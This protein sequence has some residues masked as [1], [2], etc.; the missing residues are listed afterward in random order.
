[1]HDNNQSPVLKKQRIDKVDIYLGLGIRLS[2][3]HIAGHDF[4]IR[5]NGALLAY[6]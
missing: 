2:I 3:E 5:D 6:Q 4:F 1:V